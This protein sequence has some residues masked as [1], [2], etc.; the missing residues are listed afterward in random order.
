MSIKNRMMPIKAKR[1]ACFV[2]IF[3]MVIDNQLLLIFLFILIII[4]FDISYYKIMQ[5]I[6]DF[7]G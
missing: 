2:L 4:L 7:Q 3:R 6:I 5:I 1:N